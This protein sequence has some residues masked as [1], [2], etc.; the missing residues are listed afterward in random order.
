MLN[1]QIN[2]EEPIHFDAIWEETIAQNFGMPSDK[3][4]GSLLR[5]LAATRPGGH[6]LELGT[7]TGI[8]TCWLLDGM[9]DHS[10][11]IT[12]DND[13]KPLS[14]ARKYLGNDPRIEIHLD[15]GEN[16]ISRLPAESIDFIF[17][18]AWPGKYNHLTEALALLKK[19]GIYLI[20]DMLPQPNWP[21]GHGEK[22]A[23]LVQWFEENEAFRITKMNWSTGLLLAV[24]K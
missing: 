19:G 17:A 1:D 20:D 13:E 7:G 18:D 12:V 5:T 24:K 2:F 23:R 22:A 15:N 4:T 8:S 9:D 11:L 14:V 10:R 3:Q 21:A 6:L 16:V